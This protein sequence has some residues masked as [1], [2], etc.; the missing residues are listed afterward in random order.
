MWLFWNHLRGYFHLK[1]ALESDGCSSCSHLNRSDC[2][3]LSGTVK[4]SKW[5][6]SKDGVSAS[7]TADTILSWKNAGS[8]G[9][10]V[11]PVPG[12]EH[13]PVHSPGTA[14]SSERLEGKGGS[15]WKGSWAGED[16]E[17]RARQVR[18]WGHLKGDGLSGEKG[19]GMGRGLQGLQTCLTYNLNLCMT[20]PT[21]FLYMHVCSEAH[22]HPLPMCIH[23]SYTQSLKIFGASTTHFLFLN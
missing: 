16:R 14:V 12:Q 1:I 18:A 20:F 7:V 23:V 22:V 10:V 4:A 9:Q 3:G 11:A 21:A 2:I 5:M 17:A 19:D 15:D 13:W 6:A 8:W